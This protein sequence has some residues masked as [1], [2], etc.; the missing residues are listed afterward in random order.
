MMGKVGKD[1]NWNT[2]YTLKNSQWTNL[3][4][5][6]PPISRQK[7]TQEIKEKHVQ[8]NKDGGNLIS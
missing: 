5:N 8:V 7:F 2:F 1:S 3:F 6:K 4:N